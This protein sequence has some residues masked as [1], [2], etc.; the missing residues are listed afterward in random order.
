MSRTPK[1]KE[2]EVNLYIQ[3][4]EFA[5]AKRCQN[6]LLSV[7]NECL[8]KLVQS[9]VFFGKHVST[10]TSEINDDKSLCM[11]QNYDLIVQIES[12]LLLKSADLP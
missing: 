6:K 10:Q 4:T 5:H 11:L 12:Y 9:E 8:T 2:T 1:L 7:E 3:K